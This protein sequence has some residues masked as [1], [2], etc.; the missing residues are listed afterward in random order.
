MT[1]LLTVLI[2][3]TATAFLVGFL[4]IIVTVANIE[5]DVKKIMKKL[6]ID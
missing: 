6:E 2:V 1:I 3:I 5:V 4:S